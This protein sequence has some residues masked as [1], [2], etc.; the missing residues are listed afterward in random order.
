VTVVD[1]GTGSPVTGHVTRFGNYSHY[2]SNQGGAGALFTARTAASQPLVLGTG[3]GG[4]N[5][6]VAAPPA[7]PRPPRAR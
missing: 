5:A 3:L 2:F 7:G 4:L 1:A 6:P